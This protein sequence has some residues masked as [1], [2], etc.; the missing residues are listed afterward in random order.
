MGSGHTVTAFYEIVPVGVEMQLPKSDKP[1]YSEVAKPKEG[2][3]S[4]DWLTVKMRYKHPLADTSLEL[5]K[6]LA[7]EALGKPVND[8]F[9][10][11]A[12]VAEFGLL[13]RDSPYKGQAE[14]DRVIRTSEAARGT[15]AAGHRAEFTGLVK[16]AKKLTPVVKGG[17]AKD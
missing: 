5:V 11:A 12:A 4:S 2:K 6:P 8:Y 14:F 1:I 17:E 7:G 15:D 3:P 9:R 16:Q 13:L 10:F